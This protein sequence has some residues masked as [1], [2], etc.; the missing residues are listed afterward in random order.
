MGLPTHTLQSLI[1]AEQQRR[2]PINGTFKFMDDRIK[3]LEA[4]VETMRRAIALQNDVI[5]KL[6]QSYTC[7][8]VHYDSSSVG[9]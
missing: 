9:N 4:Q 6:R 2:Y 7:Q 5:E 1:K 3:E 8:V